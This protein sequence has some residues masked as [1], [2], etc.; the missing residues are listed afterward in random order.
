MYVSIYVRMYLCIF[1]HHS[2][3]HTHTPP[4]IYPFIHLYT[5]QSDIHLSNYPSLYL[6]TPVSHCRH[7]DAHPPLWSLGWPSQAGITHQVFK[8][9]K[10][11]YREWSLSQAGSVWCVPSP[12]PFHSGTRR[13]S[14]S[15]RGTGCSEKL[16]CENILF[17][18]KITAS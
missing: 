15:S 10:L 3:M 14:C 13:S 2:Y 5:S 7:W 4:T 16:L 12:G 8:M 18:A 17:G 1:T 11:R 9:K 6:P